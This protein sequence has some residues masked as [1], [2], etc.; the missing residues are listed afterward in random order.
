[1]E[2][3]G[4]TLSDR[5]LVEIANDA[6]KRMKELRNH[7]S[8]M[9]DISLALGETR[10]AWYLMGMAFGL[11]SALEY[12]GENDVF[13]IYD[14]IKLALQMP[15][16]ERMSYLYH[17]ELTYEDYGFEDCLPHEVLDEYSIYVHERKLRESKLTKEKGQ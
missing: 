15:K 16:D 11:Q 10:P 13:P 4:N 2:P 5:E 6:A 14:P 9:L 12:L 3:V 8:K 1:M 17:L 7:S